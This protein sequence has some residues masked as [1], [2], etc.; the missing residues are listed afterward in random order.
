MIR[1]KYGGWQLE[2]TGFIF[3]LN[4]PQIILIGSGVLI[5]VFDFSYSH[6][7][8]I[9]L[10]I[11]IFIAFILFSISYFKIYNISIMDWISLGVRF[12]ISKKKKHIEF[13]TDSGFEYPTFFNKIQILDSTIGV[14]YNKIKGT[15][16]AVAEVTHIGL[17]LSEDERAEARIASWSNF[18]N[19]FCM[20]NTLIDRISVYQS[21][22][23]DKNNSLKK[24]IKDNSNNND[25]PKESINIVNEILGDD[26][27][28]NY[29]NISTYI[30]FTA[31][32]DGL[33][34][35]NMRTIE[36]RVKRFLTL[37][38]S[39]EGLLHNADIVFRK[40]L[41]NKDITKYIDDKLKKHNN[42]I[43]VNPCWNH[44][45]LNNNYS[46]VTYEAKLPE[47]SVRYDL[48]TMAFP[49][50]SLTNNRYL[51]INYKIYKPSVGKRKIRTLRTKHT[52]NISLRQRTGQ[53]MSEDDL[54]KSSR[55][56]QQDILR[57]EGHQIVGANMLVGF[58]C[59]NDYLGEAMSDIESSSSK[60]S[61]EL[62][63]LYG[64]QDVGFYTA[65]LLGVGDE[66]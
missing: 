61:L 53:I 25:A 43:I 12:F 38:S 9:T 1:S 20:E 62:K 35:Y 17:M 26:N 23:I 49:I 52:S 34:S 56:I 10:P 14:I 22:T 6:H 27:S 18:L 65:Q 54:L 13:K 42:K 28:T 3:S 64:R 37:L 57:A 58:V 59:D 40:W 45:K 8:L 4:I 15:Y 63:N 39:I 19:S 7:L 31:T 33:S 30:S 5:V 60:S 32:I 50:N 51:N 36:S 55:T 16:T 66:I 48:L 46:A 47:E 24:W 44:L 29:S 11:S 2:K 21:F 41:N